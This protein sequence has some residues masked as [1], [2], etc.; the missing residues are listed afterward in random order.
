LLVGARQVV[1]VGWRS[2]AVN[3]E[4]W[5]EL[6]R[7][8][9]GDKLAA[10]SI[11]RPPQRVAGVDGTYRTADWRL[12]LVQRQFEQLVS[13]CE[14]VQ[15]RSHFLD[16]GRQA[17]TSPAGNGMWWMR[18]FHA[19]A[20]ALSDDPWD[21]AVV[22]AA[23]LKCAAAEASSVAHGRQHVCSSPLQQLADHARHII[24]HRR[25]AACARCARVV[26]EDCVNGMH[27]IPDRAMARCDGCH[28]LF[29]GACDYT[30]LVRFCCTC[31]KVS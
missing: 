20:A 6:G 13:P 2:A 24:P 23:S 28:R 22:H 12:R 9:F 16:D 26:C 19:F 8:W 7:R 10:T 1:S 17:D 5:R 14:L 15:A 18:R 27:G 30:G 11:E 25:W 4:L 3:G 29:C 21:G 31:E